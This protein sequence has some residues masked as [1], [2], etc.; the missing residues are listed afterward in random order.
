MN[1]T[2]NLTNIPDLD[3]KLK[4]KIAI[5]HAKLSTIPTILQEDDEIKHFKLDFSLNPDMFNIC[6]NKN[7]WYIINVSTNKKIIDM[8][9]E[10]LI[11]NNEFCKR[12]EHKQNN[13]IDVRVKINLPDLK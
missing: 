8:K 7:N 2:N 10:E 11:F 4:N 1:D 5:I 13:T 6:I 3:K 12:D 9:T